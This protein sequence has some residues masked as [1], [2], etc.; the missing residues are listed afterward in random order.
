MEK[1]Y[2]HLK[3]VQ[4][5]VA[6]EIGRKCVLH[7]LKYSKAMDK[8]IAEDPGG[9]EKAITTAAKVVNFDILKL[10]E[11]GEIRHNMEMRKVRVERVLD[12]YYY[13]LRLHVTQNYEDAEY[14]CGFDTSDPE[15]LY[16]VPRWQIYKKPDKFSQKLSEKKPIEPIDIQ[17]LLYLFIDAGKS[18]VRLKD[19]ATHVKEK[20]GAHFPKM[21]CP[22]KAVIPP[23][24]GVD[25]AT[26]K[27]QEKYGGMCIE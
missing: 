3:I 1:C 6:A 18:L 13:D 25:R 7:T 15:E 27:A 9:L 20:A 23:L 10:K 11:E 17:F 5:Q 24:K 2:D 4:M 14:E 21:T 16:R 8:A 22:V 26:E 12:G 19:L